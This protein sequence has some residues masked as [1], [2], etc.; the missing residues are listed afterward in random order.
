MTNIKHQVFDAIK[1]K[2]TL[3]ENDQYKARCPLCGDSHKN[4]DKKR[5]YIKFNFDNSEPIKYNCF[6]CNASGY[7]KPAILR[8]FD[9]VDLHINAGLINLNKD[10]TKKE[11]KYIDILSKLNYN[12]PIYN[13]EE[14]FKKKRYIENRL[15][16]SLT[17]EDV[18]ALKGI[19][20]IS[21]FLLDNKIEDMTCDQ[22]TALRIE[23]YYTGF[24]TTMNDCIIFRNI[25]ADKTYRHIKYSLR[26]DI[27]SYKFYTIPNKLNILTEDTITINMAEGVYDILGVFFNIRKR[28]MH[29]NIYASIAS[30][31]YTT[32][33]EYYLRKGIVGDVVVNIFSDG[34]KSPHKYI[35]LYERV[36]PLVREFNVFYNSLCNDFGVSKS[37]ISI[38]KANLK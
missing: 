27:P 29:N 25:K 34:D 14:A 38:Y 10:I 8:A 13:D 19:L 7:M 28:E 23:K 36:K 2:L 1:D 21:K 3:V 30:S 5:F 17:Y 9:K 35:R 32:V 37:K 26:P 6:N 12:I 20:N 15:G 18:Q 4:P 24:L 33:L 11:K 22:E 31:N 16:I